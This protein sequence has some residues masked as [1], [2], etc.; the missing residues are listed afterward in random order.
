V[1]RYTKG[2]GG[3]EMNSKLILKEKTEKKVVYYYSAEIST[4]GKKLE[5]IIPDGEIEC[6]LVP[7][8]TDLL[9]FRTLKTATNDDDG[10]H[11]EWLYNHLWRIIFKENCPENHFFATG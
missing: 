1:D 8:R 6:I 3:P 4:Y 9:E 10:L 11:A 2:E 7:G 5:D